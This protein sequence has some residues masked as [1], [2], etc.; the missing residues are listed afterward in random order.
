MKRKILIGLSLVL[1]FIVGVIVFNFAKNTKNTFRTRVEDKSNIKY[2]P[3][4]EQIG[5]ISHGIL[6]LS[7]KVDDTFVHHLE[8]GDSFNKFVNIA[9][10]LEGS[11]NFKLLTFVNFEQVDFRVDGELVDEYNFTLGS[12][13][14]IQIPVTLDKFHNGLNEVLFAVAISPDKKLSDETRMASEM[15]HMIHLRTTIVIGEDKNIPEVEFADVQLEDNA[16]GG[17]FISQ[18]V[19]ELRLL[20]STTVKQG[21]KL[22]LYMNVGTGKGTKANQYALIL[23][24]DWKQVNIFEDTS[25][26]Y[27]DIPEGKHTWMPIELDFEEKGLKNVSAILVENPYNAISYMTS[28]SENSLRIGV[29]VE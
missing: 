7:G 12:K 27:L 23:L 11:R 3:M 1:F 13:E 10:F 4:V 5:G 6:D 21:D 22:N 15:S 9:N 28:N 19:G 25:V 29:T 16:V 2:L 17:V 8:I 20:P 26:V 18:D 14:D 24:K